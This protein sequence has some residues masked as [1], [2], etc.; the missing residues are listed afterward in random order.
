[1]DILTIQPPRLRMGD[2]I[3]IVAPASTIEQ[4]DGLERGISALE[5]MGFRVQYDDRIFQ[6]S[7]YLAGNDRAR[8]EELLGAFENP[9][10]QAIIGL[11][12]GYGCSRLIP[13]L[14]EKRLRN[15]PKI[16]MGFSDLTTLHLYFLNRLG[17]ITFHGPMA[18]SA[19]LANNSTEQADH[20]Y[21]L[22]TDPGYRP[23]L[24]FEQFETWSP[25]TAEGALLGGCLSIIAASIGTPYEIRTEGAIL[26]LEDQGE[27]P[28]RLDRMITHL[29]LAGKLES[30]AGVLLG[31]FLDCEPSQG[32]YTAKDTLRDLLA[33]LN[34]PV[35]AGFPA[36]HGDEN[37]AIPIG[38]KV[39]MDATARIIEF[40]EPAVK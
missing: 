10:V 20:L 35:L 36:G 17:W 32:G 21:S 9:T 1:M 11:R 13:L 25:G 39:R 26:F 22:L 37:W 27:P 15:H 8:A 7:R 23:L 12:G 6:S 40:L 24:Q 38:A 28:Y 16:F 2:T 30:I 29:H 14:S 3:A 18:T 34:V 19:A 33:K 31:K 4:R 5:K